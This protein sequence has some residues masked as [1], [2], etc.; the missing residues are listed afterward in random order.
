M[1]QRKAGDPFIV[2]LIL[3]AACL[4]LV[5][6]KLVILQV[7]DKEFWVTE[8]KK[9]RTRSQSI[10]FERGWILD[11][12]L[13]P[14]AVSESRYELH[15]IYR[16]F[17]IR[18]PAGQI[19]MIY[20]LSD[21]NEQRVDSY[22]VYTNPDYYIDS[23]LKLRP[24][25]ILAMKS[26]QKR[27]DLIDYLQWLFKMD[28]KEVKLLFDSDEFRTVALSD[29]PFFTNAA[30]QT[31]DRIVKE[32][33]A[34][35]RLEEDL[36]MGES[37]LLMYPDKVAVDA[38]ELVNIKADQL[39]SPTF[40]NL[41]ALR[42]DIDSW[43]KTAVKNISHEL[44][45]RIT[46]SEELYPGFFVVENMK[47]TYPV[48][49]CPV[50]I[51]NV[52]GPSQE[53]LET[54]RKHRTSLENLSIIED[55]TEDEMFEEECLRVQI[56]EIDIRSDE[57]IGKYGLEAF[58]EP[59][60]RGKRGYILKEQTPHSSKYL[61]DIKPLRGRDVVLTIDADLQRVSENAIAATGF[62]GAV[63]IMDIHSGAVLAMAT[64]PRPTGARNIISKEWNAMAGDKENRPLLQRC[65]TNYNLPPPGSV[66]KLVTSIAALEEGVCG[67]DRCF[68]CEREFNVGGGSPL[69]C[70]G[71]HGSIAMK[72]AL[73]KSCN[74]YYYQVGKELGYEKLFGWFE[75]FGFG[76]KSGILDRGL[77]NIEGHYRGMPQEE[78][79][80]LNKALTGEVNL[81]RLAI[82]QTAIDDVTPLQ[83]AAMA[84][85]MATGKLP[86][87][88][89]ILRISGQ[90]I[91][92]FPPKDLGIKPEHLAFVQAA[93]KDVVNTRAGTARPSAAFKRDL[94]PY[95]VAAKTGTPQV[96]KKPSHASFAGYFPWD[97]PKYSFA[98]FVEYCGMHGGEM[99]APVLNR[100]LESKEALPYVGDADR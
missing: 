3:A 67:P 81:M 20:H 21:E 73:V 37:V 24:S 5:L 88:H 89:L 59:V 97:N 44:A 45:L 40:R 25:D 46:V 16:N 95:K 15:F 10:P 51:G 68:D 92:R 48:D 41:R 62:P 98:V 86:Q 61:E 17:R 69:K 80:A 96:Y 26:S 53:D 63:V 57:V 87:P 8:A 23:I 78:S 2:M 9:S 56:R 83:V 18:S 47:R 74:I 85:A 14:L 71:R 19:S 94:R 29:T 11:R 1:R 36:D 33:N 35:R 52:G 70:E 13:N 76:G 60:L 30:S 84:A 28:K 34:L 100:I 55:K 77:Y 49:I 12:N 31:R 65:I 7:V 39:E 22:K 93:M 79:G 75:K 42:R 32:A 90:P 82:G 66:A 99:A 43:D 50:L 4:F 91:F 64:A 38:D 72:E 6:I 27:R 58:L 54:L